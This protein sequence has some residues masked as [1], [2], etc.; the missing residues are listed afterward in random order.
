MITIQEVKKLAT[1]VDGE[2][3]QDAWLRLADHFRKL[4]GSRESAEAAVELATNSLTGNLRTDILIQSAA[5]LVRWPQEEIRGDGYFEAADELAISIVEIGLESEDD[6][7]AL[8]SL[9]LSPKLDYLSMGLVANSKISAEVVFE[10]ADKSGSD[11]IISLALLHPGLS[12]KQK[13]NAS[14]FGI[15]QTVA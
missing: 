3:D 15:A 12:K 9:S 7:L 5:T 13:L 6:A 14:T 4:G 2:N 11:P 8:W 1:P 10:I